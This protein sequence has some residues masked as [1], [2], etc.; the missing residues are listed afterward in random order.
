MASLAPEELAIVDRCIARIAKGRAVAAACVYGSKAAGYAR[1]D[2]DIDLLVV[3]DDYRYKV[4]YAYVK[5]SGVHVSALVVDKGALEKD[6]SR[7][8]LGEFV[9]GRLLH[10]YRPVVNAA[11]LEGVERAC[12]RRIILEELHELVKTSGVLA[13]E[14]S[15]PLEYVLFSKVKRRAALYPAAAYSYYRTYADGRNLRAAL[16][17]YKDALADIVSKDGELFETSG[18][19][20]RISEKR[21]GVA[22]GEPALRLAQRMHEFSSYFIHSYAGRHMFHMA[23]VEAEAKIRRHMRQPVEF[24]PFMACPACEYLSLPEG[25]L[26]SDSKRQDWLDMVA[27][28]HGVS[29]YSVSRRRLGNAN[30]RTV[31]Y[32][33]DGLKLAVKD[34]SKSKAVKWAAL[35]VWTAPVKKFRVGPLL[36][37]GYEY[38][39][40]RHLRKLGL[41]TPAVEAVVLDRKVLVLQFVE[42]R[43]VAGIIRDS[44]A[45]RDADLAPLRKAGEQM[46][47]VHEAGHAFGNIKPKNV[48]I[49]DRLYFTDLDQFAFEG[50][51]PAWDVAEFVSWGLKESMNDKAAAAIAKEFLSGYGNAG[52]IK[53]VAN[54]RRYIEAFYPVLV[55]AVAQ[56]IKKEMKKF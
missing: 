48:I 33:L 38:R 32:A 34:M 3:L 53:K 49:G 30:S 14:I 50:G 51:D 9:A 24:P 55:P 45:S 31:L 16:A 37:L 40:L 23:V 46:A 54:S 56:A 39:A 5:E 18:G 15:F 29:R 28:S 2:S 42:G 26:I 13:T 25:L 22:K 4:K 27:K 43:N 41:A 1:P 17:G 20:I 47:R 10:V 21:I 35:S 12:K 19:E 7:G 44:L 52:V 36:R 11:F 8:Y 6:A